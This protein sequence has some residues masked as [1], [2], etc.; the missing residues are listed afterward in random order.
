MVIDLK[1][2]IGCY[3]CQ[4]SCKAEH[5]TPPGV[6]FARVLKHEEGTYPSVRQLFLPVLCNHCEEAPCVDAC[7]TGASFKWEDGVVDIDHDK[8]VGCKT[9]M[10]ACPYG[11]RYFNDQ[12]QHYFPQGPTDYEQARMSR[13]QTDVVMKC[14]FCRER[15]AEGKLPACVANC[16]TIAR[17]FGDLDDPTSEVSRL[18][19][20]RGG[21]PLHP[22][23]GTKP[24][25]Y[26]LP[27]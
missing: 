14:N 8:C 18:I 12:A 11:N 27:A 15:R 1:R 7:P 4:L 22:E 6:F 19:K 5:G 3:A 20:E 25:V 13:H 10:M 16:P 9:C 26:Y 24:S 21:F 17:T 2:C 23:L